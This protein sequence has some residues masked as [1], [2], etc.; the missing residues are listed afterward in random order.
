MF[1]INYS[2]YKN[3]DLSNILTLMISVM[4]L[5][6]GKIWKNLVKYYC[7]LWFYF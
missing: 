3:G 4:F 6:G 2:R 1:Y 7:V 5:V